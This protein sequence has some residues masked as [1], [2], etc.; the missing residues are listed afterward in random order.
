[1]KLK[2]LEAFA[3]GVPVVSTS[4]GVE[5]I[6]AEDGVHC[7]VADAPEKFAD[8]VLQLLSNRETAK[9]TAQRARELVDDRYAWK[10]LMLKLE[11]E[12]VEVAVYNTHERVVVKSGG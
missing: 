5:G 3:M 1:M 12:L 11:A 4:I 7:A 8:R 6:D 9:E 2:T 10:N